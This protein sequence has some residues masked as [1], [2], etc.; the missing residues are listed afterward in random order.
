MEEYSLKKI[1]L[2]IATEKGLK[3]LSHIIEQGRNEEIA[4]VISFDETY[5]AV[6]H[7][8][9]IEKLCLTNSIPFYL[10][11]ESHTRIEELIK[12]HEATSAIA[13]SWKWL[14]P[15]SINALLE[16][17]LIIFH[18]SILPKYRGFAPTPTAI[19]CG[20][21]EVGVSAIYAVDEMDKGDIILQKRIKVSQDEY[22][23]QI[24]ENVSK[25]YAETLNE[26]MD[27]LEE[28]NIIS[29]PQDESFATYS[30][31]RS[32]EDCEINWHD[33]AKKVYN[34]IR[35]VGE[36]YPGAFT[37]YDGEKII[38]EKAEIVDD[39]NFAD[40]MPGKIWS[41]NDNKPMVIC[42]EGMIEIISA[43]DDKNN[44]VIFNKLRSRLGADQS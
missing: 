14:I 40:R 27:M 23:K 37:Y 30:I 25:L 36:P 10:W 31:W 2:F 6:N 4:C 34:L 28:G 1:M 11:K 22:I 33:D 13:I 16:D 18:D 19:I 3:A 20:E 15:L 42:G 35:A 32:P 5:V 38:I 7:C 8:P 12:E 44:A 17:D 26:L 9:L 43:K 39:M 21:E 41:I 29:H 24:I